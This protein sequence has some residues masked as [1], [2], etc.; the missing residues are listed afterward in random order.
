M[1]AAISNLR[2]DNDEKVAS[3]GLEMWVVKPADIHIIPG[4]NPR[5]I[6]Y[7]DLVVSDLVD[8]IRENGVR[9]LPPVRVKL[10]EGKIYLIVG[11]RRHKAVSQLIAEGMDIAGLSCIVESG[12]TLE[13]AADELAY[14]LSENNGVPLE[15]F[16][17]AKAFARLLA[18]NWDQ[19]QIARKIGRT[20]AHVSN[21]LKLL[22]AT[23]ETRQAVTSGDISTTDIVD[24]VRTAEKTGK[25]Q[26]EVVQQV[27]TRKRNRRV[28][29]QADNEAK[30]TTPT[31]QLPTDKLPMRK[32]VDLKAMLDDHGV[33]AVVNYLAEY[34]TKEEILDILGELE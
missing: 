4:F 8:F 1:P 5:G 22:E 9:G 13:S 10:V 31:G 14:A 2:T 23:P 26:S 33:R 11:H 3:R 12:K 30:K 24:I 34:T 20:P 25:S 7:E 32:R 18:F 17:E 29:I 21:R 27:V 28:A 15:P 6:E 19:Q 16:Q